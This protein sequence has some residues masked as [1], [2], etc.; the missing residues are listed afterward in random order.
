MKVAV[1]GLINVEYNI[2]VHDFPIDYSPIEYSFFGSDIN[3]SGVGFN[4]IK[5]LN[6]LQDEVLPI[7]IVGKDIFSKLVL[8]EIEKMGLDKRFI[9]T[10]LKN[11]CSS[12][13]LFDNEG[14][15][16]IYCDL[17]EIQDLRVPYSKVK[18]EI[19]NC[20]VL[21]LTNISFNEE[22]LNNCNDFNGL[23]VSDVH[24]LTDINDPYNTRFM[25]ASDILFLSDEGINTNYESFL[26]SIYTKYK[27]E[28]I[29]LGMGEKGAMVFIKED[30]KVYHIA[31]IKTKEVI[32]TIGAGDALL[33]SF[34]HFYLKTKEV[35]PSLIK[36]MT[37]ASL[38]ISS[39]GA[40]N[41][42][43]NEE[44]VIKW[45]NKIQPAVTLIKDYSK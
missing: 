23:I 14:R 15:R 28:I 25:S 16:K 10:N 21:I 37:F 40:S 27:N 11:I 39:S 13:V 24:V 3:I 44:E 18:K 5:A 7:S 6:T 12:L 31:A 17:K 9:F 4:I 33:S 2:K 38:K 43:V 29:V 45:V 22:I 34:V 19:L 8:I 36:A 41:G 26:F 20:D 32:N 35:L 30:M 42:F 1:S